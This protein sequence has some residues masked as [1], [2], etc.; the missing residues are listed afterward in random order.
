MNQPDLADLNTFQLGKYAKN[1]VSE[2]L[3][4]H[5][6]A[7]IPPKGLDKS[8]DFIARAG[9]GRCYDIKVRSVRDYNYIFFTK[10]KYQPRLD[11]FAA[12]VLFLPN[13]KPRLCLIPFI[14]WYIKLNNPLFADRNYSGKKSKP[15]WGLN[16]T[17]KNME[18]LQ[19]YEFTSVIENMKL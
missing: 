9:N 1:F 5:G 6:F 7:I 18:Y 12:I 16:V 14:E 19:E 15:E 13:T 11:F 4:E 17:R 3:S 10:D 2:T 8:V